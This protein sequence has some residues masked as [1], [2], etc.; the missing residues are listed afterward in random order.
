M[1]L[2]LCMVQRNFVTNVFQKLFIWVEL[3]LIAGLFNY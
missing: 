3:R 2:T 1:M